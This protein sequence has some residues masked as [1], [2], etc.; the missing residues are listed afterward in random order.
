[1]FQDPGR[2]SLLVINQQGLATGVQSNGSV[3]TT[4]PLSFY[5]PSAANPAAVLLNTPSG[6]FRIIVTGIE[7]GG[8]TLAVS[9]EN[10][11]THSIKE[12]T[13]NGTI[14]PG[15]SLV[16]DA[17][18]SAGPQGIV[19]TLEAN[20]IASL[21]LEINFLT[22]ADMDKGTKNSLLVKLQNAQEHLSTGHKNVSNELSALIHEAEA[23]PSQK[24]PPDIKTTLIGWTTDVIG[25]LGAN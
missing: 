23:L 4:I 12:A 5:Y 25:Q 11:A 7:A 2:V 16:Y 18:I 1:M 20:P 6:A 24:L 22:A 13:A 3:I 15:S 8:F 10:M 21:T 17:M 19:L 9:T 14:S